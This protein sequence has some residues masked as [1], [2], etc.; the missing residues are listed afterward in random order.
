M[1]RKLSRKKHELRRDVVRLTA[2]LQRTRSHIDELI[3][4]ARATEDSHRADLMVMRYRTMLELMDRNDLGSVATKDVV[5]AKPVEVVREVYVGSSEVVDVLQ[6][7]VADLQQR[8][9]DAQRTI[10]MLVARVLELSQENQVAAPRLAAVRE[11]SGEVRTLR[12]P[13]QRES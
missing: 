7:Q 1:S 8:L 3:D 5:V 12:F 4:N 9:T 10:E 2:E 6:A 13:L 11:A